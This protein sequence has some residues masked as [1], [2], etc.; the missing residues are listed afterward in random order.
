[1]SR[2]RPLQLDPQLSDPQ[3]TINEVRKK[4]GEHTLIYIYI[5][6]TGVERVENFKFLRV[7]ITNNLSW[8]SHVDAMVKKAQHFFYRWLR[9]F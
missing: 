4:G 3:A 9:K 1:M 6:R 8:T 5:N 7:T 2:L